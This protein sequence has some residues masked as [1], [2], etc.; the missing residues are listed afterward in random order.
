MK[1]GRVEREGVLADIAEAEPELYSQYEKSVHNNTDDEEES[2]TQEDRQ[3]LMRQI[4]RQTSQQ[5]KRLISQNSL[6]CLEG[7]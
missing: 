1:D 2:Q 5:R 7:T 3:E 4:S 6:T